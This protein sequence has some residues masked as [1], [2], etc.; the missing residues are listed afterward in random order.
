VGQRIK[1]ALQ[2]V[3]RPSAQQIQELVASIDNWVMS[4]QVELVTTFA[5]AT[6]SLD[7]FD[8]RDDRDADQYAVRPL[9][10]LSSTIG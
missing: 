6:M 5:V 1:E 10:V 4:H 3:P 2:K 7:E 8:G 9:R